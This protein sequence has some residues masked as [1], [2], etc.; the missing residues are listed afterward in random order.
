MNRATGTSRGLVKKLGDILDELA[1]P[2]SAAD[3]RRCIGLCRRA[4]RLLPEEPPTPLRAEILTLLGGYLALTA[5]DHGRTVDEAL[6]AYGEA[7]AAK[8]RLGLARDQA[9][10]LVDVARLHLIRVDGCRA[11]NTELAIRAGE[12]ALALVTP[13]LDFEAWVRARHNLALAYGRRTNSSTVEGQERALSL[14]LELTETLPLPDYAD[15]L[16]STFN[17]LASL[18]LR[19]RRGDREENLAR[20]ITYGEKALALRSRQDDPR[21]WAQTVH[22]L[23]LAWARRFA[24]DRA[25]NLET[26]I[27]LFRSALEVR[28]RE[29]S[30]WDWADTI[31]ALGSAFADRVQGRRADNL[32]QA[33]HCHEQAL[34]VRRRRLAPDAWT[35]SQINR[36][37]A[38]LDQRRDEGGTNIERSIRISRRVL[39]VLRREDRPFEWALATVNLG[40]ALQ[41]RLVGDRAASFEESIRLLESALEILQRDSSPREWAR[42]VTSLASGYAGW[43]RGDRM[44]NLEQAIV[45]Y[46][47][48]LEV[49]TRDSMPWE[50]A[51]TTHNLATVLAKPRRGDRAAAMEEAIALFEACLAVHTRMAEPG[52]WAVTLEALGALYLERFAGDHPEN[53]ERAISLLEQ[54]LEVHTRPA[55]PFAW[56]FAITLLGSAHWQR[57]RGDREDNLERAIHHFSLALEV[58]TR[59]RAPLAWA[60]TQNGLGLAWAAR[61][62]GDLRENRRRA[63]RAFRRVL[64]VQTLEVD[65]G[66]HRRTCR[67]LGNLLFGAG[68]WRDAVAAYAGALSAGD[69]LYAQGA[70]PQA[71][72]AEL[73]ERLDVPLR[74]AFALAKR[75]R[76]ADAVRILETS[77]AHEVRERLERDAAILRRAPEPA[78]RELID[79]RLRIARLEAAS[80]GPA[81]A[82]PRDYLAL[83][84]ELREARSAL[85]EKLRRLM[86]DFAP[87]GSQPLPVGLAYPTVYLLTTVHGTLALVLHPG[88]EGDEGIDALFLNGLREG[89][90]TSILQGGP[91]QISLL[92]AILGGR[93]DSLASVVAGLWDPIRTAVVLP[94][95][96]YLRRRCHE[97]ALLVPCGPLALL[98]LAAMA[99]DEMAFAYAPSGRIAWEL[100]ARRTTSSPPLLAAVGDPPSTAGPLPMAALEAEMS[101]EHFP[102]SSRRLL[103]GRDADRSAVLAALTGATH[104]HFACHG[105]FDLAQ[106]LESALLLAGRDR[107]TVRDLLDGDLDLSAARLVVLS[108]CRTAMSDQ[109]IPDE[110]LG[111]PAAFL[112]AGVPMVLGTLWQVGD[113]T[114]ALLA[115][116]FYRRHLGEGDDAVQALRGAQV[117]IR[118]GT[119]E[120][121]GLVELLERAFERS[122][123]RSRAILRALTLYRQKP[124]D[125]RPFAAPHHWAGFVVWGYEG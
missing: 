124:K 17:N 4:L 29:A 77:R 42:A 14:L 59:R 115:A 48:A 99:L 85:I 106:P 73:W 51:E 1:Q 57:G 9:R 65:P 118:D 90:L 24:G 123:Q 18:Y 7:V 95:V 103:L 78:R 50:W 58:R 30:P 28:T 119:V 20:A 87:Q 83:S 19:R 5:R 3:S 45:L 26:A 88:A 62:R 8:K 38:Y 120:E 25:E 52:R 107:L 15:L 110:I 69:L 74:T 122:G 94:L 12:E 75:G 60:E 37:L 11:E 53:V 125:H 111:F 91:Q 96:R 81:G 86:P 66:E 46:R 32:D 54:A 92:A 27:G 82:S 36:A 55:A 108:A 61:R 102:R 33:I 89:D 116:D 105:L 100:A 93:D 39:E 47:E 13:D 98:P 71:R 31:D 21:A 117:R 67:N 40:Q 63:A 70:T 109:E 113:L 76:K 23:A 72:T 44:E 34:T 68:R 112:Q 104:L 41:A 2:D 35:E 43:P 101:A 79:L 6:T 97:R 10:I 49:R 64:E 22:N 56:A 80:R 16:G 114:S 84:M 121:L